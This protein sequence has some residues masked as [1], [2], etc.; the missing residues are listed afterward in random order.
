MGRVTGRGNHN[1]LCDVC[2]FQYKASEMLRR[3]DGVLVCKTDWE[4]RHP[5]DFVRSRP[6]QRP[7]INARPQSLVP[8]VYGFFGPKTYPEIEFV[9]VAKG[10]FFTQAPATASGQIT[11]VQMRV[12]ENWASFVNATM[13]ATNS[14]PNSGSWPVMFGLWT[15]RGIGLGNYYL[16]QTVFPT[17]AEVRASLSTEWLTVKLPQPEQI[18]AGQYVMVG[19][20]SKNLDS[21]IEFPL[22]RL[23]S[24]PTTVDSDMFD[25]TAVTAAYSVHP[26]WYGQV[27]W[28][29]FQTGLTGSDPQIV[30]A[31]IIPAVEPLMM[32]DYIPPD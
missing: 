21:T 22:A 6:D 25:M 18:F 4:P 28:G 20:Q 8:T 19:V 1:T 3:W 14:N 7:V 17:E 2:G 31:F 30:E 13:L 16:E 5:Q 10:S 26:S 12:G 24:A 29:D 32:N 27:A 15:D 11:H 9:D 23:P